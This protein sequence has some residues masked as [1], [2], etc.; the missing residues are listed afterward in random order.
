MGGAQQFLAQLLS[1]TAHEGFKFY[2]VVGRG[3]YDHLKTLLPSDVQYIVAR[4]LRREPSLTD[5]IRSLFELR[6]IFKKI[7]PDILF[8]NS[9]KAGF[10][11][12]WAASAW[13]NRLPNMRV[14]YRIG[15]WTFNDPW[16]TWKKKLYAGM[17]R[18]SAKWK[19]IIIVNN[20]YD[21]EQA[22]KLG[23]RPRD[24]VVRI[25]NGIDPYRAFLAPQE[26]RIA[27][28]GRIPEFRRTAPYDWLV[29]TIAN[30]YPTKGLDALI[31][32]AARVSEN[33]RFLVIGDGPQRAQLEQKIIDRGLQNRFFLV[34][35]IPE[36][37]SYL[38]AFDAFVLPSVKEGFSWSI[39]EAMAAKVPVI[40]TRVGAAP[41]MLEDHVSGLLVDPN[42][43]EQLAKALVE[44]FENDRLR[45]ELPIKAH[46]QVLTRFS[47][48]EM[49]S[50]Y[51]KLFTE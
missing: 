18:F 15:G 11:G 19:D 1:H 29:G 5:D 32:A 6:S 37:A 3:G 26:A 47:L 33:V 22:R 9:S 12:S 46:Q 51:E 36:A 40:A 43:P 38:L 17:E 49:V 14:I 42:Q 4:S 35:R 50:Q 34:G 28:L 8:L 44:I 21:L 20:T 13:P 24:N 31:E 39:L 10:N 7:K 25:F 45:Q 30:F 41:E 16:P 2:V 23:I 48:R 27:L